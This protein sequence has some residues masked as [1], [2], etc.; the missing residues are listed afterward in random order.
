M[1]ILLDNNELNGF[2]LL[3]YPSKKNAKSD[4]LKEWMATPENDLIKLLNIHGAILF[5]GFDV[6]ETGQFEAICE[7]GTPDLV[8]YTGGGSPRTHIAGKIYTSTEYPPSLHIPLHCEAT[9]FQKPPEFIWLHCVTPPLVDGETPIGDMHKVLEQL[10]QE[11]ITQFNEKNVCYLYNLHDGNNFGRGWRE[12]F[13][14]H[15]PKYVEKWL[16][17]HSSSWHWSDDGSLHAEFV[18]PGLRRHTRSGLPTWGNQ[19]V[20][21]HVEHL[22]PK[23]ADSIKRLYKSQLHYPKHALFGDG[24]FIPNEAILHIRTVLEKNEITF[25]WQQGDI[26]LCDNQRIAHGRQ[27]FKGERRILVALS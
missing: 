16:E 10:D 12:T 11:L 24:S 27:P 2:P 6:C 9:Y 26:L 23:L 22:P 1:T 14:T 8:D 20:N 18:A 4:E 19:A 17:E 15:D 5:R 13:G 21:W 7:T 3:V 25:S